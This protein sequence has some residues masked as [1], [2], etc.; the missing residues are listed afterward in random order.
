[1]FA[2]GS[3]AEVPVAGRLGER[4]VVGQ[5][6]RLAVTAD[7]ILIADYKTGRD[8][9]SSVEDAVARYPQY[10][11][12]LALY[13][14]VLDQLYSG[15]PVRAALLWTETPLLMEI[16]ALVLDAALAAVLAAGDALTS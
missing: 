6:D 11:R 14:A 16:P 4:M 1:L 15:R 12:Q 10:I 13:R 9:P 7:A 5:V 3:R 2:P 8:V